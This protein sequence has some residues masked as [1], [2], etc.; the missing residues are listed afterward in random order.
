MTMQW[1]AM[2][3]SWD[4]KKCRELTQLERAFGPLQ[5]SLM[6]GRETY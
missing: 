3:V 4:K 1:E 5:D 6:V 2:Y